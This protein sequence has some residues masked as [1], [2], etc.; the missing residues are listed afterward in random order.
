MDQRERR[1]WWLTSDGGPV[2]PAV[3][4]LSTNLRL[5]KLYVDGDRPAPGEL[6]RRRLA[7]VSELAERFIPLA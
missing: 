2:R 3:A 4:V 7:R 6:R 5:V 1:S